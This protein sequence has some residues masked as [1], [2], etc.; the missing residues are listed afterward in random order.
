MTAEAGA[1]FVL[2]VDGRNIHSD[3]ANLVFEAKGIDSNRD[4]FE[5]GNVFHILPSPAFDVVLCLGLRYHVAEPVELFEVMREAKVIVFDTELSL[6]DASDSRVGDES[7][8]E[9]TNSIEDTGRLSKNGRCVRG[10]NQV[11]VYVRGGSDSGPIALSPR[12]RAP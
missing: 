8:D 10:S 3:H 5:I 12:A 1:D 2:G 7:T 4:K 9:R 11:C 6:L